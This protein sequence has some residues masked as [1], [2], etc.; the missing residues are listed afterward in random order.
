MT[1]AITKFAEKYGVLGAIN[2]LKTALVSSL[3]QAYTVSYNHAPDLSQLSVLFRNVVVQH[4]KAIQELLNAAITF[5]RETQIKLPGIKEA[6]LPE[7][8]KQIKSS[9]AAV[10]EEIINAVTENLKSHFLPTLKT[11]RIVL[12]DGEILTGDRILGYLESTLIYSVNMVKQLDSLDVI[13]EKLGK[14]LQEVVEE[15]QEIIDMIPSDFLENFS[16]KINTLYTDN[17]RLVNGLIEDVIR[18]L[19]TDSLNH[20][21]DTCKKLKNIVYDVFP[22]DTKYLVH[23]HNGRLKMDISFP[24]YH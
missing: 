6:T 2:R 14:A 5:L 19:N 18:M 24:F 15:M 21:A 8:C 9:I 17:I 3:T 20:I 13:L 10:L 22:S 23:I 1:S 16:S 7:I 11:I 4:Q 12:P